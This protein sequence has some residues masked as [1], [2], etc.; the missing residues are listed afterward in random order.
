MR[1]EISAL[2]ER[3]YDLVIVGG[4][5]FGICAAWDAVSRGL[6]VALAERGDFAHAT[7]AN[8][9]KMVHGGIRYLQHGDLYRLRESSHERTALLR[10]AP[11]LVEPLP[12]LVPTY[13][14]GM[15]GKEFLAAG[16][17]LYDLLTFDRNS[18]IPDPERQIPGGHTASRDEC[19]ELF[20][21][22][23]RDEF[24][25][26]VVF[27]DG[28]M[29]NPPRLALCF[30]KSAVEAGAVAANYVE[31]TSF[32]WDG[33]RATGVE[34]RDMLSGDHLTIR[35][36][37]VLSAA[38]PWAENLLRQSNGPEVNPPLTFSRDTA[39]VINRRLAE[40]K[41]ALAVQGAT[42]DP[43]AVL[44]RG[45]RHLFMVPWRDYTLVGVWHVVYGGHPGEFT[46]TEEE[47]QSYLDEF[48]SAYALDDPLTIDDVSLWNAGLTLFG[49]NKPGAKDLSYGKRSRIVDHRREHDIYGLISLIGVRY[50]TARGVGKK[51]VDLVFEQLGRKAPPSHTD[52]MPVYGGDIGLFSD[53]MRS[54][55]EGQ[56]YG[57]R[58][59]SMHSLIRN[60]GSAYGDVL[61]YVEQDPSLAE[62][63]GRSAVVKAEVVHAVRDEAAQK[64]GDVVFRRTDLGSGAHPGEDALVV[65]ARLMAQELGWSQSR[66]QRELDEVT[67][68][69][70]N[71]LKVMV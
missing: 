44:N 4:G 22:L 55:I 39:L 67:A 62:T 49:D 52:V 59:D 13:G 69:L 19:L 24:S 25:S 61:R 30:L 47:I 20:P 65:C 63:V 36:R 42:K 46:V 38:G 11:H 70:P 7:S 8:C 40:S 53:F 10:I 51:A 29:Y 34:A 68:S 14:R 56:P 48:N 28:H 71:F 16:L 1:R 12:I 9:F 15:K 35:G 5:I 21:G 54:A 3:E 64:L 18:G 41:Y 17:R 60:H 58:A 26:G 23:E 2:T 37:M 33:N 43:D 57:I 32:I 50:T 31:A 27:H 66:I 6:S 45:N